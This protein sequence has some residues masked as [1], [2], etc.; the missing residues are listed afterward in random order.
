M[1]LILNNWAQV[2]NHKDRFSHVEAKIL[3]NLLISF[4]LL[5][6]VSLLLYDALNTCMLG[7]S[8][9]ILLQMKMDGS[10]SF[11]IYKQNDCMICQCRECII[12][13]IFTTQIICA[14]S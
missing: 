7:L 10:L 5:F 9:I 4:L 14:A 12:T 2:E 11:W 1:L 6:V 8:E 13:C 3:L